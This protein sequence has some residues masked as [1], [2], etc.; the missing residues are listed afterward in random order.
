MKKLF[1][2]LIAATFLLPFTA[3]GSDSSDVTGPETAASY[4]VVPYVWSDGDM[5]PDPTLITGLTY[6]GSQI[7]STRDGFVIRN[8]DRFNKLLDLKKAN[9]HLKVFFCVGGTCTSG[10]S[11]LAADPVKRNSFADQC[12]RLIKE[13]G[14]DGIDLDWE[15]PGW[16]GGTDADEDNYVLLLKAIREK[17]GDKILTIAVG[18]NADGIKVK[19]CMEVVDYFN[20]MTY[21]MCAGP[22]HHTSLYRSYRSGYITLDEC[23]KK[24]LAKGVTY[25]KMMLGLAFYGRGNNVEFKDW[26]DYADIKLRDG[27]VERWDDTALVP[28]IVNSKGEFI[29]GY[30]N[31][32]SLEIKC[33]Y[34]KDKGFR[35]A[36][37][38]R[39]ECD[40]DEMTLAR[41]VARCLLNK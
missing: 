2:S 8:E 19:E 28:Y 11:S 5:L 7:N 38:W 4:E 26:T 18:N 39:T 34:L 41:T 25:D 27:M 30:D 37:M 14:V 24:Y 12:A 29:I 33:D 36:M 16:S 31:P 15:F 1:F 17:I 21:D 20:V 23:I 9:P 13:R 10:Y 6:I 40:D 35:G 22:T 32:R 3:C